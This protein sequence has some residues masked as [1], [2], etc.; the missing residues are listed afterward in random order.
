MKKKLV[1]MMLLVSTLLVFSLASCGKITA[2]TVPHQGAIEAQD[3][4]LAEGETSQDKDIPKKEDTLDPSEI[5][6][7][8]QKQEKILDIAATL[9]A[10]KYGN[11][12]FTDLRAKAI[13]ATDG[14]WFV[15]CF[16][17]DCTS[18]PYGTPT[19]VFATFY[20]DYF[21]T[22]I[23]GKLL[24]KVEWSE[25]NII[26]ISEGTSVSVQGYYYPCRHFDALSGAAW[27]GNWMAFDEGHIVNDGILQI[28]AGQPYVN[29]S[30]E[31][32][33]SSSQ[34][35]SSDIPTFTSIEGE[36][37]ELDLKNNGSPKSNGISLDVSYDSL[38][39]S[40]F[41]IYWGQEYENLHIADVMAFWGTDT[42]S[43]SF[44]YGEHKATGTIYYRDG[45]IELNIDTS[46]I[47]LIPVSGWLFSR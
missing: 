18:T 12:T 23:D 32:Q 20:V 19:E 35:G 14:K 36:W 28:T 1:S 17:Y 25:G 30:T 40:V 4:M 2:E 38:E 47:P 9:I 24:A 45:Y 7:E 37:Q 34:V 15:V 13:V 43:F 44:F 41:D 46:E 39:Y 6:L 21:T 31:S 22:D 11:T 26:A 3:P 42:A 29:A 8:M 27:A 33:N 5:D 16:A 10:K